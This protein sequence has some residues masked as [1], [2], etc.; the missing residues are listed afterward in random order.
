MTALLGA[1]EAGGT[2]F[3]CA[4]ARSSGEILAQTTHRDGRAGRDGC[5]CSAILRGRDG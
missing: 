5:G 3:V 2:K 4:A 1:I